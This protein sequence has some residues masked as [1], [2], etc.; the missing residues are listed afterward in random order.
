MS[1]TGYTA[2]VNAE[3]MKRDPELRPLVEADEVSDC[4]PSASSR[5]FGLLTCSVSYM[6]GRTSSLLR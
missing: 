5:S 4:S 6:D 1:V 2:T 3:E